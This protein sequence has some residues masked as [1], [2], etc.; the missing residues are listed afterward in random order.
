M[1]ASS[2]LTMLARHH[3][4]VEPTFLILDSMFDMLPP[5]A[6]G[7][8]L[9][10]LQRSAEHAQ[11]ALISPNWHGVHGRLINWTRIPLPGRQTE[12]SVPTHRSNLR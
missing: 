6:E 7:E 11:I 5:D 1:R 12:R 9:E 8:L 3:A 2:W 10:Q 4:R